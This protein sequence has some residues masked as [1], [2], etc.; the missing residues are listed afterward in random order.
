MLAYFPKPYKNELLYSMISRYGVHTGQ[1]NN[2]KA[3]VKDVFK[4]TS[5]VAIP[6][7][8]SHINELCNQ[9]KQIWRI[10]PI[11]IVKRHTLASLYLPFLE[12]ESSKRVL[13]SMLS[14]YGGNIHT[15]TGIVASTL[16]PNQYFRFCPLCRK[17]QYDLLGES[18]WLRQHQLPGV[19]FCLVHNCTLKLSAIPFY[20]KQKHMYK[21]LEAV[22]NIDQCAVVT[23]TK[24]DKLFALNFDELLERAKLDG[25]TYHQWTEFYR[26][27]ASDCKLVK[28]NRVKHEVIYQKFMLDWRNTQFSS[29]LP[30]DNDNSWLVHIF[31]KHRKS[32]HPIRHVMVWCSLLASV[33]VA[34]IFRRI[35]VLPKSSIHKN[36]CMRQNEA[37]TEKNKDIQRKDWLSLVKNND[38]M[39]IKELRRT[40][41][42]GGLYAWLY[43]HDYNWLERHKPARKAVNIRRKRVN[44][45]EWD[46]QNIKLLK[47]V[48]NKFSGLDKRPQLTR[49]FFIKKIRRSSSVEKHLDELP[50]TKLWLRENTETKLEYRKFRILMAARLLSN[51]GL[52]L[53]KWRI[54]RK[55]NVRK[56]YICK[57]V[58]HLIAT[59]IERQSMVA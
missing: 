21:A 55:A 47:S 28:G 3:I 52:L 18:Y 37:T 35:A 24:L 34:S 10:T 16:Q 5:A 19:D 9:T 26:Q 33:D 13:E 58:D 41:N 27:L 57:D 44:Y 30:N 23:L 20:P 56:E 51:E 48:L 6:D 49:T 53:S 59:L 54:L 50:E 42:G 4:T 2:Q 45:Q 15:R 43:R 8:P 17:Q 39:G 36:K 11:E 31:R 14:C 32:F 40:V 29:Y 22:E 25:F 46:E 1:A 7:L 12:K 38:G